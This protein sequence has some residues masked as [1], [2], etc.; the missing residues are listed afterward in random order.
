MYLQMQRRTVNPFTIRDRYRQH[1]RSIAVGSDTDAMVSRAGGSAE[2]RHR[3][4]A[5]A[6]LRAAAA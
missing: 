2:P 3:K 5:D 1:G 6:P 4:V